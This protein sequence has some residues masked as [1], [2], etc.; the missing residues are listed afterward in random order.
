MAG[1]F[2]KVTIR[3]RPEMCGQCKV[4]S[5]RFGRYE[6]LH[7]QLVEYVRRRVGSSK[8]GRADECDGRN[9]DTREPLHGIPLSRSHFSG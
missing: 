3:Y 2:F 5:G 8:A 6:F 7:R 1:G 9:G 4:G